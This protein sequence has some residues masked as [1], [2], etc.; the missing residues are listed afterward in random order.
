MLR[1]TNFQ[2][3]YL[4]GSYLILSCIPF[5]PYIFGKK[6][7]FPIRLV[8]Y[9][10]FSW[11]CLWVLFKSPRYLHYALLPAFFALPVEVYL[12]VYF[13][14][15][16]SP[17]HLG[18]I[19][20]TSPN[21]ALEFLGNKIWLLLA[22]L[23]AILAWWWSSLRTTN[24]FKDLDW[25]HRSRWFAAAGLLIC[26]LCW[27]YGLRIGVASQTQTAKKDESSINVWEIRSW[28]AFETFLDNQDPLPKWAETFY[29][30]ESFARS[31]P[32]GIYA[33]SI[34]FFK[35]RKYLAELSAK[36]NRFQFQAYQIN[37]DKEM[38]QTVVVVLGESSRY[39]R[40]SLNGYDRDTN[41][42]LSQEENLVSLS[43]VITSV[44][45]TRLSVPIIATRKPATQSLKPGFTEKSFIS[46]YKEAG[47][48]TF[49]LSNQMSFGQ[50]DTP[51]SV[52]AKEAD[53]TRFLN[54]G[55]YTNSSSF[56]HELFAPF[57]LALKDQSN[58]KLIVLH[59]LGNHWNYSHRYPQ[60]YDKWQPS[61]FG[62]VNPAYTNL[63]NKVA[64]NNSYD[65]S[66]L[67]TDWVLSNLIQ[68]LK[69]QSQ[70]SAL[71]YISDHGQTLYDGSCNLAFHGH[72]T[73]FEFHVPSF[74]W[75]SSSFAKRF[76]EKIDQL[77]AHQNAQLSTENF[78]H[79]VL[80][81]AAIHYPDEKLERSIFHPSWRF[82]TRYV[83]SYGWSNYDDSHLKG[84]CREVID[85]KTPLPQEK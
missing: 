40:W 82:H 81:L 22:S 54:L 58:K 48:K 76:P 79:S 72:N 75:F 23:I 77:K 62:V 61:L 84:D 35:E 56:D 71:W 74:V 14:Q 57:Q 42:Y 53:V 7:A 52:I 43:D 5:I 11:F 63:K 83:D 13:G 3:A 59:T 8:S 39:D 65:N 47:F 32:L 66:I 68:I 45:A 51:T 69:T 37:N 46:A 80:D 78:F 10:L 50:F 25:Q 4:L 73:Q 67:Y 1:N 55:G 70:L 30:D 49:W 34:D 31:W 44:A 28:N 24:H 6:L 64:I 29:D 15:G 2:K 21:E 33:R 16:I 18:I 38:A 36:N 60:S 41:P 27:G 17:H 9:E 12:Q 26:A 20:E 85:N 19:T